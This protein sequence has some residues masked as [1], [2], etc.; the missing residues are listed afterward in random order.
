M[1]ILLANDKI[2]AEIVEIRNRLFH[3]VL[4]DVKRPERVLYYKK[5]VSI[6]QKPQTERFY[7][8]NIFFRFDIHHFLTKAED[9]FQTYLSL[10]E[11]TLQFIKVLLPRVYHLNIIMN[12]R[13][14]LPDGTPKE[15]L[16]KYR[17]V[18]DKTGIK[19]IEEV[20]G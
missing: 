7:G 3:Q 14:Y 18:L 5:S 17:L 2:P 12:S 4:E 15:E 10:D 1:S 16:I 8:F 20:T 6:Q 9:P 11:K 13:M 19:R